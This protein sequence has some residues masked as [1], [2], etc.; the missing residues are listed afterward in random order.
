MFLQG[1]F[2]VGAGGH[3]PSP[4]DSLVA[5]PPQ[6]QKLADYFDV[7]SKVPKCSKIQIF[8]GGG[9]LQLS[10]SLLSDGAGLVAPCQEPHPRCQPLCLR[11]SGSNPLQS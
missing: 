1:Q 11:V 2:Y 8:W 3:L 10:P 6:I 7:I 5:P 4:P 9:N